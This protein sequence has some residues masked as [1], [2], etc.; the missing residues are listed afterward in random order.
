MYNLVTY[1]FICIAEYFKKYCIK[2]DF[3]HKRVLEKI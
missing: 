1:Y 2:S 3:I